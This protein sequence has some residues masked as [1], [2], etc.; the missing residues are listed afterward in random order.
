MAIL[1]ESDETISFTIQAYFKDA[2]NIKR[3]IDSLTKAIRTIAREANVS[4][5][6][7]A[8][9]IK[10]FGEFVSSDVTKALALVK[11]MDAVGNA[12][13]RLNG[14]MSAKDK[15]AFTFGNQLDDAYAYMEVQKQIEK[16]QGEINAIAFRRAAEE[17][18]AL[19][20]QERKLALENKETQEYKEQLALLNRMVA[21]DVERNNRFNSIFGNGATPVNSPQAALA[22]RKIREAEEGLTKS[23]VPLTKAQQDLARA[24][25]AVPSG[26][27]KAKKSLI[28][29]DNIARTVFGTL[30]AMAVFLVTQFVQQAFTKAI[31][32]VK[33]LELALYNL[34]VAEKT[35]SKA[36]ISIT[37]KDFQDII[38][39]VKDLGLAISDTDITKG[40]ADL[41]TGLQDL[42]LSKEQLQG[43]SRAA[44]IISMSEGTTMADVVSQFAQGIAKGGRG[45][46]DLDIQVDAAVIKQ[47]A[48]EEGLVASAEEWDNLD[49]AQKQSIETQALYLIIMDSANTKMEEM[50]L[51]QDSVT[52]STK[53]ASA[54]WENFTTTLGTTLKPEIVLATK[55][56]TELLGFL[57]KVAAGW[58]IL[59]SVVV[60]GMDAISAV[61]NGRLDG[62]IKR[63]EDIPR[64][65]STIFGFSFDREMTKRF[66]TGVPGMETNPF[67]SP[68]KEKD[69]PTEIQGGTGSRNLENQEDLQKALEK[70]NNEILEAQIK[71]AQ[72]ME[73]AAIDLGRKLE[74][75][76]IEYA[77]KRADAERDYASKVR[78]INSD[79]RNKIS[80]INSKQAEESQKARNDE[81]E[82]EA[83]FQEE[84][85]QLKEKFLMDMDDAIRARDARQVL[86]LIKQYNLDRAQAEREHA[87]DGQK[88]ARDQAEKKAQFARERQDAERERTA[89]LEEAKRTYQDKLLQLKMDEDAERAAAQLAYQRK[90]QDLDREMKDRLELL[91]AGL[92]AE[93][94]LTKSG[95][96]A[97][98]ALYQK[99]YSE[100]TQIYAAMNTMLAGRGGYATTPASNVK[101]R[102]DGKPMTVGSGKRYAEGG[103]AIADRPTNAVFGERGLEMATFTPLSRNGQ[104]VNKLFSSL[105]GDTGN[106]GLSQIEV[107]LSPG[108]EGRIVNRAMDKTA[109]VILTTMREV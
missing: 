85:R 17:Q 93:F 58:G 73:E 101:T 27:E 78:D 44:A 103:V 42:G 109:E 20:S 74:D 96:D 65:F 95:M 77:K 63:L 34:A 104:N 80:E 87:L 92:I 43:L 99:Y 46:A 8:A 83:K 102:S 16:N 37:P 31:E 50:G 49:A 75:I 1:P 40:V 38:K 108:L 11:A 88:A 45:L 15:S 98:L 94:N 91:A 9:A 97:I 67:L 22:D 23:T 56:I 62:T 10:D 39:S 51:L 3:D 7:A 76:T 36:G 52:Q 100:I 89:K 55:E 72:D 86:R 47:K 66:P 26:A 6:V 25:E 18:Q 69:T 90:M 106:G 53:E 84:M 2:E 71:L 12:A 57:Q 61:I 33:Q 24:L 5:E 70:M 81:L 60:A 32:G 54:E 64:I 79:Y 48:L 14:K 13:T 29:L 107:A 59:I 35:L 28:S 4:F 68:S 105:T 82:R 30:T 41:A 19:V 21:V